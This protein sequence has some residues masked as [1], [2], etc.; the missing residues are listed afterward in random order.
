MTPQDLVGDVAELL[1]LPE[2][3]FRTQELLDDPESTV[4]QLGKVVE[5]DV[6]LTTRLLKLV[7]SAYFARPMRID[8]VSHAISLIGRTELQNIILAMSA[9]DVFR[10]I[11]NDLVDMST[12]WYH[13]VY[14]ALL[15]R[16]LSP[17]AGILHGERM[18]VAG[19]LHDVGH[20]VL[21]SRMPDH[22]RQVL[23]SA[24][25]TDGGI[26]EMEKEVIGFTHA[27][28]GDALMEMW[29]LPDSLRAVVHWH[30]EPARAPADFVREVNVV[31]IANS[32]AN[33]AEA[34]RYIV[35]CKSEVEPSAWEATGLSEQ[36]ARLF[37]NDVDREVAGVLQVVAP[38]AVVI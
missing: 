35:E 12:F 26:Y 32:L 37:L 6:A 8:R 31:H 7:N 22:S 13:S 1:S 15:A 29:K 27:E 38:G 3:Y 14:A 36:R 18:F 33:S 21:Y 20:L 34:G 30:H 28:V 17:K 9:A 4:D 25:V 19:L 11:P 16:M 10:K 5:Y 24:P 2:V 23:E